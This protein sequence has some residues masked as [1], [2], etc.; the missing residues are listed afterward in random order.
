MKQV[1]V[2]LVTMVGLLGIAKAASAGTTLYQQRLFVFDASAYSVSAS[3]NYVAGDNFRALMPI[4]SAGAVTI[5][6][7]AVTGSYAPTSLGVL[8]GGTWARGLGVNDGG[9]VVGKGDS[10][11][12]AQQA[13]LRTGS[14]TSLIA[15]G[16]GFYEAAAV[17]T[18]GRFT[19][20]VSTTYSAPVYTKPTEIF[21]LS[22]SASFPQ[23]VSPWVGWYWN[24]ATNSYVHGP[25]PY[26]YPQSSGQGGTNPS[27][28][29][30]HGSEAYA[31]GADII[32][33]N[34]QFPSAESDSMGDIHP[35][36]WVRTDS[37]LTPSTPVQAVDLA[38]GSFY[39]GTARGVN[40]T[41]PSFS[42]VGDLGGRPYRWNLASA[43]GTI[44]SIALATSSGVARDVNNAGVAVGTVGTSAVYWSSTNVMTTLDSVI[45]RNLDGVAGDDIVFK[46]AYGISENGWVVGIAS[47]KQSGGPRPIWANRGFLLK[48]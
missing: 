46:E 18:D 30:M 21:A 37:V 3:A 6:N 10:S 5:S 22:T 45:N 14:G 28:G 35:C 7:G 13:V 36:Y 47:V 44:T 48:L 8:S 32:A 1:T 29:L 15:V 20:T 34:A 17:H 23:S 11:S 43:S 40:S 27:F 26:W 16:N 12:W 38:S 33:G 41:L 2:A 39:S 42:V 19:G 31:I 9:D 4:N 25:N 24:S